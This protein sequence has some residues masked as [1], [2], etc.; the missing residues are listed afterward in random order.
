MCVSRVPFSILVAFSEEI[1]LHNFSV[2]PRIHGS[3]YRETFNN[4]N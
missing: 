2:D 1:H 4:K 3:G